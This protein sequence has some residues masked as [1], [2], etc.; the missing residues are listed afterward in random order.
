[1]VR[2]SARLRSR[3]FRIHDVL[4]EPGREK[5]SRQLAYEAIEAKW[6]L[7]NGV[8]VT[9]GAYRYFYVKPCDPAHKGRKQPQIWCYKY[10][11][12]GNTRS[13]LSRLSE[14]RVVE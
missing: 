9:D 13:T 6:G 5:S 14:W 3:I 10:Y 2:G 7:R 1:M 11:K 4:P 8:T 12:N